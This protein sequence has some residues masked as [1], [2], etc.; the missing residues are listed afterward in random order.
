M[1]PEE[2]ALASLFRSLFLA[3]KFQSVCLTRPLPTSFADVVR[4]DFFAERALRHH[5]AGGYLTSLLV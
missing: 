5:P 3:T 1:I 4:Y 2:A